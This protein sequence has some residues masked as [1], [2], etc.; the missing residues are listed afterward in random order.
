MTYIND[1]RQKIIQR[2]GI[3]KTKIESNEPGLNGEQ[4]LLLL[5]DIAENIDQCL[6]NWQK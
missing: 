3:L 2:L 4:D 5:S 1:L 6:S